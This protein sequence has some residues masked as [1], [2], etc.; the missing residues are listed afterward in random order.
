MVNDNIDIGDNNG[1]QNKL[2]N[3]S[4]S[5]IVSTKEIGKVKRRRE[6]LSEEEK[7][8]RLR[9]KNRLRMKA[10]RESLSD[11][12]KAQLREQER[13]KRQ[14]QRTRRSVEEQDEYMK[15]VNIKEQ[16]VQA[17]RSD[18]ERDNEKSSDGTVNLRQQQQRRANLSEEE[19]A[20]AKK[21][22]AERHRLKYHEESSFAQKVVEEI[23]SR[24]TSDEDDEDEALKR[25]KYWIRYREKRNAQSRIY[26]RE[27]YAKLKEAEKKLTQIAEESQSTGEGGVRETEVQHLQLLA[28]KRK[29]ILEYSRNYKRAC[30]KHPKEQPEIQVEGSGQGKVQESLESCAEKEQMP[31][32]NVQ[33]DSEESLINFER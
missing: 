20:L 9:E 2:I 7:K 3:E 32:G 6:N 16:D 13:I 28:D 19:R 10:F 11:E 25:A 4:S 1:E 15:S 21:K 26:K 8:S 14:Q 23:N 27:R 5:A 18:E 22:D 33:D 30:R 31:R 24:S 17:N 12:Q 29:T